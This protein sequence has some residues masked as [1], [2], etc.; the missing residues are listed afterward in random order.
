MCTGYPVK[1][2]RGKT[3]R[4]S[5]TPSSTSAQ[6]D[7]ESQSLGHGLN[8]EFISVHRIASQRNLSFSE[9]TESHPTKLGPLRCSAIRAR[10]G[11]AAS[12]AARPGLTRCPA[13][14][15][16]RKGG[17]TRPRPCPTSNRG[18]RDPR[19]RRGDLGNSLAESRVTLVTAND[20]PVARSSINTRYFLR[21]PF[22]AQG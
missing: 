1:T 18:R 13:R 10:V 16:S 12:T 17:S 14:A 19:G 5:R 6:T 15:G 7:Q 11:R 21:L 8:K 22:V 3:T 4:R 9:H 20:F 2:E